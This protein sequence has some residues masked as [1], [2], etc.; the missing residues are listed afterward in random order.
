M[1]Y[2]KTQGDQN[3][4]NDLK[5]LTKYSNIIA[6]TEII[7]LR[8]KDYLSIEAIGEILNKSKSVV[9]GIPKI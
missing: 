8:M 4:Q 9:H 7:R 6:N 1:I 5:K 2:R 3:D